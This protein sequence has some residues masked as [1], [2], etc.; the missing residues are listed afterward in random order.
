MST[1]ARTSLLDHPFVRDYGMLF[2]LV[3]L[4]VLFSALTLKEQHPTDQDAARQVADTIVGRYGPQAH[5]LIV[6]RNTA[7]DLAFSQAAAERLKAAGVVVLGAV[8]G[9]AP[10]A[11]RAIE[12]LLNQGERIDAIAANDVT[13]KW[14]VYDRFPSVGAARCV[15]PTP[16]VWPDFL[17]LSNLLGVAN[18]TAIYAIIAI[19]MTMVIITAGI[20]LSVGSLVALASVTTAIILRDWGGGA[21]AGLGMILGAS[22]AGWIYPMFAGKQ[23]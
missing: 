11:R 16:Y 2:V 4:A 23:E 1:P 21:N 18:Q 10:D 9:A 7:E 20:D 22:L 3:L 8:N 12:D 13:A 6:T 5:A 15:V 14:A 17:K 19:G